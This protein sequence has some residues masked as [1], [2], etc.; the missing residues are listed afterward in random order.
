[1]TANIKIPYIFLLSIQ[2]Q[3]FLEFLLKILVIGMAF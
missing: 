1:M 2:N 3:L